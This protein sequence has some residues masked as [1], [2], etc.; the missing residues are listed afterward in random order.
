MTAQEIL[1]YFFYRKFCERKRSVMNK[2]LINKVVNK[3]EDNWRKTKTLQEIKKISK[4]WNM[5]NKCAVPN[6]K[7][8]YTKNLKSLPFFIS[9]KMW[10]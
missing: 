8:G 9:L 6:C 7:S 2:L 4:D 3:A 10:S 1:F 5:A